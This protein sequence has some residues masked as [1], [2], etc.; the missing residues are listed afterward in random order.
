MFW[1]TLLGTFTGST[2]LAH[3]NFIAFTAVA[4]HLY[5]KQALDHTRT[6]AQDSEEQTLMLDI[7][8][9]MREAIINIQEMS[10]DEGPQSFEPAL[11]KMSRQ[12]DAI[13]EFFRKV[14]ADAASTTH[15]T[16]ITAAID[17]L[18]LFHDSWM[19]EVE[20]Q[21]QIT[22]TIV[23]EVARDQV[24]VFVGRGTGRCRRSWQ[25]RDVNCRP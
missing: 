13:T 9:K 17:D 14:T 15:S 21:L 2:I 18:K 25:G 11:M 1:N 20:P 16:S 22:S 24:G 10:A 23:V 19:S 4:H 8:K 5:G 6:A 7:T 12:V 3:D